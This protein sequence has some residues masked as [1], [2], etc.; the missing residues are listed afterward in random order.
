[1]ILGLVAAALSIVPAEAGAMTCSLVAGTFNINVFDGDRVRVFRNGSQLRATEEGAVGCVQAIGSVNTIRVNDESMDGDVHVALDLSGGPFG[2]GLT[3]EPSGIS[4][5]EIEVFYDPGS[6]LQQLTIIGTDGRDTIHL[7]GFGAGGDLANLNEDE[8]ID[9]VSMGNV[10]LMT[11]RTRGG[12]DLIDADGIPDFDLGFIPPL[13]VEAGVGPDILRAGRGVLT[14]RMLSG[15]DQVL[16]GPARDRIGGGAGSDRLKGQG[17]GDTLIGG[18]GNDRLSGAAGRDTC[19][20]GPGEDRLFS[21]E[22]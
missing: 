5:I 21:C 12:R 16:G 10:D 7:G 2:P 9:D 14:A 6:L 22:R 3:P 11:V 4:E 19:R 8:D 1:M 13:K 17:R 20:G 18:F 15:N